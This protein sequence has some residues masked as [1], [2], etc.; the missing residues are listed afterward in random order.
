VSNVHVYWVFPPPPPD[1]TT[2]CDARTLTTDGVTHFDCVATWGQPPN[3]TRV[4][5]KFDV[6]IDKTVPAVHAVPSRP[7]DANGW[8]NHPVPVSFAGSDATSGLAASSCSST[9]YS[10]PD[11]ASAVVSGTCSDNAGNVGAATFPLHYDATPPTLGKVR[12]VHGNRTATLKWT[13]SPDAALFRINRVPGVGH[14]HQTEVYRGAAAAFRDKGLRAGV[15]YRYTLTAFDAAS[16]A[17]AESL[18]VMGTGALIRPLPGEHVTSSPLLVWQP[19]KRAS[20]Y[21]VQLFRGGRQIFT[22]W[23]THTSLKL[24]RS[25]VFQGHRYRLRAG[26]YSWY[27]WPGFGS[28][29]QAHYGKRLGGSTFFVGR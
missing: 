16:N 21:N 15:K 19:T 2:G 9:T 24:S 6:S 17:A 25:W 28:F 12:V 18:K 10:G 22:A 23:P 11:N 1:N 5:D 29:A 7:P 8:Y 3:Q 14:A 26:L 13:A 27:V 20:Y 4:E